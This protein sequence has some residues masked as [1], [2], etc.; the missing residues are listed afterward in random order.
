MGSQ[1]DRGGM[2]DSVAGDG[3]RSLDEYG[4]RRWRPGRGRETVPAAWTGGGKAALTGMGETALAAWTGGGEV[5]LTC[6]GDGAGG[7]DRR[8]RGGLDGERPGS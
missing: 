8:R 1:S 4:R 2:E 6:T 7:L 3:V 5:A